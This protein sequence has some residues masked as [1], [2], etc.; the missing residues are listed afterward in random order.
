MA[1]KDKGKAKKK[2]VMKDKPKS[3][4]R[5]KKSAKK[6]FHNVKVGLISSDVHVYG[7]NPEDFD[8][9]VAK[10]DL[11]RILKGRNFELKLRIR[12]EKDELFGEPM[13][14]QIIG[15]YIRRMMRKGVDY[16]ED[17]FE[18]ETRDK[19]IRV[20][21]FLITR[22]KVSRAVR[23]ELRDQAKKWINAYFK[24][25]DAV[26]IF[27]EILSNKLQKSLSL[28]LKKVYPL[29]LC[30]IRW[31]EIVGDK[32]KEEKKEDVDEKKN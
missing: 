27:E 26:E 30:E 16:V 12:N 8:G 10:V 32:D 17:S 19:K 5:T 14:L 22:N 2:K 13:S 15:S 28:K 21:P 4:P 7:A 25:R 20:K 24:T 3:I 6:K 1:K 9:R 29:S 23:R 11:T 18:V 31:L